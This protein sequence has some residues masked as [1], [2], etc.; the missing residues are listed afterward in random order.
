MGENALGLSARQSG[1]SPYQRKPASLLYRQF[2]DDLMPLA[3]RVLET[4]S[5]SSIILHS[6]KPVLYGCLGCFIIRL[7]E[8]IPRS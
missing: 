1:H 6:K 4:C 2:P 8:L 3:G 7:L 5:A